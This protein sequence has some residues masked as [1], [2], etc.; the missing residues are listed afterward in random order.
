MAASSRARPRALRAVRGQALLELAIVLFLVAAFMLF[1][2]DLETSVDPEPE[3]SR[4]RSRAEA[5]PWK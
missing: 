2:F 3:A 4:F 5:Q 1:A